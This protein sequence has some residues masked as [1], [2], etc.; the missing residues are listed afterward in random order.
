MADKKISGLGS[1]SSLDGN[2]YFPL[3][4][5]TGPTTKRTL[6]STLAAWLFDQINIPA[7]TGSPI[8]RDSE[9]HFDHVA[10][11]CVWS[12][13][14]YAS[15]RNASMTS[16]LVYINGRRITI[17]SVT[18]RSFTASK[19][20]YVDILDNGDGTGTLVYTEVTNNAASPSLASNSIRIAI[21]V[22]GASN[23]ASVG[24][25]NQ[26]QE[27]KVLPIASSIPYQV[28]DSLG[29][30]ICS[31][32]SVRKLLGRRQIVSDYTTT[33]G[34]FVSITGLNMTV[35]I[36]AGRKIKLSMDFPQAYNAG[37]AVNQYQIYD[38]TAGAQVFTPNINPGNTLAQ[39]QHIE[40]VITPP[41]SGVRNYRLDVA[42]NTGTYHSG[43]SN[44]ATNASFKI[45]L[46]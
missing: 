30:L 6:L 45:E 23:I 3:N 44:Q 8:T 33:S 20:T 13:D 32:D 25:V 9:L 14:A 34:S 16:G 31:R 18:A 38:V 24:S 10:S 22:T 37:G 26:G 7:G 36:P 39:M 2:H 19:D 41:A 42:T 17:G 12:G 5:P 11:G 35:N 29:N 4:D 1:D 28:T 15:T 21:I 40:A 46:E 43:S 27:D